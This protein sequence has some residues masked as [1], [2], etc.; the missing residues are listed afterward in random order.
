MVKFVLFWYISGLLKTSTCQVLNK[1]G[2]MLESEPTPKN[3]EKHS[4]NRRYTWKHPLPLQQKIMPLRRHWA[5]AL[6]RLSK[7]SELE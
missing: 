2:L 7:R 6:E 5:E 4:E 3:I 1:V